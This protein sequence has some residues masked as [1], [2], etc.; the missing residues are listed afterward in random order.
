MEAQ[1]EKLISKKN[2]V[3][4]KEKPGQEGKTYSVEKEFTDALR[5]DTELRV[6]RALAGSGLSV[7]RLLRAEAPQGKSLGK[8]VYEFIPGPTALEFLEKEEL[9]EGQALLL[10]LIVWLEKFH[11]AAREKFGEPW[12]LGDI[13]LRNFIYNPTN[14]RLY[15]LDFENACPGGI[16]QD[17]ARLFLFIATYDP[18]YTEKKLALAAFFAEK[19]A[20]AFSLPREALLQEVRKEAAE[21]ARR[22][23]R[24]VETGLLTEIIERGIIR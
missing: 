7:P 12:I 10:E 11:E 15:G 19:A 18:A 1:K 17:I 21:M 9:G 24:A 23:G 14:G 5:F 16:A 13:H 3:Y 6:T 22:R 4:K 8:L 20:V 2:R